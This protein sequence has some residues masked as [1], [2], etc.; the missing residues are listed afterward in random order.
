MLY[1]SPSEIEQ[2][3][4]RFAQEIGDKSDSCSGSMPLH[5]MEATPRC[6]Q[7]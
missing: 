7:W 1:P 6:T 5:A 3:L 2:S 4:K